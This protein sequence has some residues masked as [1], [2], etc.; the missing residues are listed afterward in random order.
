MRRL[1]LLLLAAALAVA[2]GPSDDALPPLGTRL[3]DYPAGNARSVAQ[4]ACLR[5]HSADMSLQQR[6][7]EKQWTAEVDKMIRWGA[8]VP[9]DQKAPLVQYLFE[10]FGPNNNSFKPVEARPAGR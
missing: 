3:S 2:A 5:C 6:L 1:P 8:E 9:E 10:N 4:T 7:T